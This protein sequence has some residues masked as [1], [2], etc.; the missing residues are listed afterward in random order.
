MTESPGPAMLWVGK[1]KAEVMKSSRAQPRGDMAQRLSRIAVAAD[2]RA[3]SLS[4]DD[5]ERA[6]QTAQSEMAIARLA[7]IHGRRH[8]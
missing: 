3:T 5:P 7:R 2:K 1:T 4:D 6:F 8:G